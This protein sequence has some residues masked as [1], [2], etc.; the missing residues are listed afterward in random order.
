MR[1]DTSFENAFAERYEIGGRRFSA[2]AG[3]V[4]VGVVEGGGGGGGGGGDKDIDHHHHQR[5]EDDQGSEG[6]KGEEIDRRRRGFAFDGTVKEVPPLPPSITFV[7]EMIGFTSR[8]STDSTNDG[9]DDEQDLWAEEEEE[10]EEELIDGNRDGTTQKGKKGRNMEVCVKRVASDKR[11]R[12]ESVPVNDLSFLFRRPD[13]QNVF[14][15]LDIE[16]AEWEV[17]QNMPDEWIEK[18]K[19]M[20]LEVTKN[21][22]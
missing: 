14:L 18:V 6:S 5:D 12:K 10:E 20:T 15:K 2:G 8:P 22:T 4:V 7:S 11:C 1:D 21:E 13:V 3:G 17:L 19:Q 9:H 16:G